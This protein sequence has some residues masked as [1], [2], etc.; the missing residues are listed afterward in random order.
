M[1][2]YVI[3]ETQNI[4][5]MPNSTNT[6]LEKSKQNGNK[7]SKKPYKVLAC[8]TDSVF[9]RF[10]AQVEQNLD[11]NVD[12]V[13]GNRIWVVEINLRPSE[14]QRIVTTFEQETN[15]FAYAIGEI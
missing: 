6:I 11:R 3:P 1:H 15:P 7:Y 9:S 10:N 14:I 4:V 8:L 13:L 2:T 5:P 12:Y